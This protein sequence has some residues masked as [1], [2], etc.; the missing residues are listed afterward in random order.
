MVTF[1]LEEKDHYILSGSAYPLF[2]C[3]LCHIFNN[4]LPSST[5]Q[6]CAAVDGCYYLYCIV[7]AF[8]SG[9]YRLFVLILLPGFR[10]RKRAAVY[11]KGHGGIAAQPAGGVLRVLSYALPLRQCELRWWQTAF[12]L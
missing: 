8:Y 3:R 11:R 7:V 2:L 9:F 12:E 1:A 5:Y 10:A 6:F 4:L